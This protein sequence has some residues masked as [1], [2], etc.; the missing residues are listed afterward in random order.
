VSAVTQQRAKCFTSNFKCDLNAHITSISPITSRF[1]TVAASDGRH[2]QYKV[3]QPGQPVYGNMTFE[4]LEHADSIGNIRDWVKTVYDGAAP[5]KDITIEVYDQAGDTVRTF[6]LMSCFPLHFS[7]L[8]VG[9]DGTSG[10]VVRWTLEVRV[11]R[12]DMA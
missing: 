5:R 9:A 1:P 10:T 4:G 7:I 11:N 12:I 8:D 3:Y 6:N 2:W